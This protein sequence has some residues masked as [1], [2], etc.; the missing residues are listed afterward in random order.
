MTTDHPIYVAK[1]GD[2]TFIAVSIDSPRFCVGAESDRSVRAK[3]KAAIEFFDSAPKQAPDHRVNHD[4]V[5]PVYE[6]ELLCA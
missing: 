3:A 6:K 1:L 4:V 5:K 2:G